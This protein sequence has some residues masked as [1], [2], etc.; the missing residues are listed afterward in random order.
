MWRGVSGR[1]RG[2]KRCM[3]REGKGEWVEGF[4]GWRKEGVKVRKKEREELK[5]VEE[6]QR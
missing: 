6:G 2:R 3:V 1:L 4:N 5:E